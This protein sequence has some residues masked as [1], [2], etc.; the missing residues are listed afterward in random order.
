MSPESGQ[1]LSAVAFLTRW[2]RRMRG[3]RGGRETVDALD[4]SQAQARNIEFQTT[5]G[6]VIRHRSNLRADR[7][8]RQLLRCHRAPPRIL[9]VHRVKNA[10]DGEAIR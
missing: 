9:R 6:L 5:G 10:T 8:F 7:T 4:D 2:T 1:V 3:G